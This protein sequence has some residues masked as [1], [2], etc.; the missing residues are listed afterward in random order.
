MKKILLFFYSVISAAVFAAQPI[1]IRG[2][3]WQWC[4]IRPELDFCLQTVDAMADAGY[5]AIMPEFGPL[6]ENAGICH[7]LSDSECGSGNI[8]IL[9]VRCCCLLSG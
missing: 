4:Y 2:V 5:N 9:S 6:P 8:V 1:P 7:Q 3:T